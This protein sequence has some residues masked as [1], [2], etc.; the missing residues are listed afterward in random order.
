MAKWLQ[1]NIRN[2]SHEDAARYRDKMV[3]LGVDHV[4]TIERMTPEHWKSLLR[5]FHWLL[6]NETLAARAG[7][8][9]ATHEP[10][11]SGTVGKGGETDEIRKEG[12][13]AESMIDESQAK[14]IKGDFLYIYI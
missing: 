1:T 12:R 6:L 9:C 8:K 13:V 7:A 4:E 14:G 5:P 10:A 3:T 2:L 11:G